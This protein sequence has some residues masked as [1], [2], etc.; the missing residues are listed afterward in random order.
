MRLIYPD[1]REWAAIVDAIAV[2][3]EEATFSV[4]Q[5]GLRLRALDPSRTSMVDLFI[6]KEAFEEYP[7]VGSEE[8][9]GINF[10]DLK[11]VLKRSRKD[12]KVMLETDNGKLKVKLVGKAARTITMPMLDIGME[13]LPTPKVVFTVTAKLASDALDQAIKDVEIIADAIKFE[14][15]ED[16]IYVKASSDKGDVEVK[17]EKEGDVMFEYDLKETAAAVYSTDYLADAVARASS[18]SD[19]VTLEF[20]TQ[21]PIALTFEI[22]MGGKL[23]Y[24]IAPRMD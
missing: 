10:N 24:Y 17:F 4:A 8:H 16:G 15:K 19:I 14:G 9:I 21:K 5:D 22:P 13:Q 23:A 20:A 1:A 6:P 11:K 12:D 7:D 3:I 2:L 18:I